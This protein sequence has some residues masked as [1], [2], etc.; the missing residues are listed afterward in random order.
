MLYGWKPGQAHKWY[1][2]RKEATVWFY[3]KPLRNAEHPT[4]KPVG[5]PV[6]AIQNS[7]RPGEIVL[8]TFA[9]SGFTLIAAEQ[10]DR[11]AY[12]MEIDPVYC[13]VIVKRWEEFTGKKAA[14]KEAGGEH[15][16]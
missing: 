10:T 2:G 9:G 3:D 16:G 12:L 1:G 4:M 6:K 7:S 15:N 11:T 14:L 8:D 13:D 5:I